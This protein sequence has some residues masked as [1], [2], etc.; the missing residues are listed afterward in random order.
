MEY[1]E[2]I[3]RVLQGRTVNATAKAIGVPQPSLDKYVKRQTIP[4]CENGYKMVVAAGVDVTE[5]FRTLANAERQHKLR[6]QNGFVQI[7]I[8]HWIVGQ[9]VVILSILCQMPDGQWLAFIVI[10]PARTHQQRHVD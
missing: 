9:M 1:E 7:H 2:L 4:G 8:L 3:E 5:G 6:K 10:V